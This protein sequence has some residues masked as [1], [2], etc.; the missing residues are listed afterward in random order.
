MEANKV[1]RLLLGSYRLNYCILFSEPG[2][3]VHIL[4][5]AVRGTE[6]LDDNQMAYLFGTFC[7][8]NREMLTHHRIRRITFAA[9]KKY[10]HLK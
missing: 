8:T 10:F 9:L 2:E 5:I 4:S 6:D 1:S 3:P 7:K